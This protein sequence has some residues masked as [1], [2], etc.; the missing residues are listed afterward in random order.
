MCRYRV[1]L[2]PV[3]VIFLV[4]LSSC[5]APE[6]TNTLIFATNTKVA[7]DVSADTTSG[8]PSITLGYKRQNFV[9]MPL[10]AN[11]GTG[12]GVV[13]DTEEGKFVGTQS[14]EKAAEDTYSVLGSF[15]GEF[16]ASTG[17][18]GKAESSGGIAEY[19]AT[20]HAARSL[21]EGGAQLVS[22]Q[23]ANTVSEEIKKAAEDK[24]VSWN[25]DT[26]LILAYAQDENGKVSQK[27][28]E[29]LLKNVSFPNNAVF[30]S[31]WKGKDISKFRKELKKH[32]VL[33]KDMA[34]NIKE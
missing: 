33:L 20:G 25:K 5:K 23:P 34:K 27:R 1:A 11:N 13:Q 12:G 3:L 29:T 26:E 19:F 32:S 2:L 18:E 16:K 28:L 6:H 17:V 15:G 22:V 8:N 10:Y 4:T 21:A 30:I 7:L 9:W 14:G 24:L 31:N